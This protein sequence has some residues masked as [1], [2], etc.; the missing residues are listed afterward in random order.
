MVLRLGRTLQ[1]VRGDGDAVL[2]GE[3]GEVELG[4]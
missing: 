3:D 1:L 2:I 4:Y